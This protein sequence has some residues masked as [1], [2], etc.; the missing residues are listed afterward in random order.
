MGTNATQVMSLAEKDLAMG[1]AG[2]FSQEQTGTGS[3][4]GQHGERAARCSG[5]ESLR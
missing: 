3:E 4:A 5:A 1:T 2:G